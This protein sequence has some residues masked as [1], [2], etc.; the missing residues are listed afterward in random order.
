[1]QHARR[2]YAFSAARVGAAGGSY[3]QPPA[4]ILDPIQDQIL[5]RI[6]DRILDQIQDQIQDLMASVNG[7]IA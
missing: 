2:E 5:D 1:M 3:C 4:P 7:V 6:L